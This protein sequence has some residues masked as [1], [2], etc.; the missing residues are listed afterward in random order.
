[1]TDGFRRN[2]WWVTAAGTAWKTFST[3]LDYIV[4][5]FLLL[6][7]TFLASQVYLAS[8]VYA[9]ITILQE[10]K[11][12]VFEPFINYVHRLTNYILHALLHVA[13]CG[14]HI[15]LR[16]LLAIVNGCKGAKISAEPR[17]LYVIIIGTQ[18][19]CK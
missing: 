4:E 3:L 1:M 2:G 6:L 15:I 14:M 10:T 17:I 12:L 9:V 5:A 16:L 11:T 8:C 18:G 13:Y 7:T 19:K